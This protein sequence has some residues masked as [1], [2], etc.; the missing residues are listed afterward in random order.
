MPALRQEEEQLAGQLADLGVRLTR[1]R[2]E[3]AARFS[4]SVTQELVQLAM[5]DAEVVARV[6]QRDG[7]DGLVVGDRSLAASAHGLDDVELELVP[8]RGAPPRPLGKGASGGELSR[9][10]LAVEVVLAGTSPVPT[11]FRTPSTSV[12]MRETRTPALL[13]S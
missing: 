2:E 3:A 10:M 5:P 4:A 7:S 12:M 6:S 1:A 11:R 13:E 9:V 8:H